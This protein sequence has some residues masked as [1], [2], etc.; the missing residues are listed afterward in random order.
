VESSRLLCACVAIPYDMLKLNLTGSFSN[1]N[2]VNST[3][4]IN[5]SS[6]GVFLLT[7]LYLIYLVI[8]L[9]INYF[10]HLLSTNHKCTQP[11][12]FPMLLKPA[13]QKLKKI[14]DSSMRSSR[15]AI[16]PGRLPVEFWCLFA[17][18]LPRVFDLVFCKD[19]IR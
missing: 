16:T 2:L 15:Q 8:P 14:W 11:C 13:A 9:H 3:L 4:I 17:T 12:Y 6:V 19:I 7:A 5:E 10:L 1:L 18:M